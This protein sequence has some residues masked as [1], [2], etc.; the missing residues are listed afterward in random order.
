METIEKIKVCLLT[1]FL[2]AGKTTLLNKVLKKVGTKNTSVIEN[3]IGFVN[4]DSKLITASFKDLFTVSDGCICCSSHHEFENILIQ[5]IQNET[6]IHS[7]FIE[8]TGVADV[9]PIIQLFNRKDVQ[10]KFEFIQSIC[11]IDATQYFSNIQS[12]PIFKKQMI[13]SDTIV[14]NRTENIE[15]NLLN[16]Q[17]DE[18]K[19]INPFAIVFQENELPRDYAPLLEKRTIT[20]KPFFYRTLDTTTQEI[21]SILF[22]TNHSIDLTELNFI[23]TRTLTVYGDQIFR[24]KGFINDLENNT[25][26]IQSTGKSIDYK[27]H[28]EKINTSQLVFIGKKIEQKAIDR[29]MKPAL[30]MNQHNILL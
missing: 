21:N 1:G 5:I 29:I 28:T 15:K 6:I 20:K 26:I 13:A 30:I 14:V 24:I 11:V 23:L 18:I 10:Q 12:H 2:G 7:L 3:E 22:E 27:L 8:T 16:K 25:Y 9:N 17:L 4:I 19:I